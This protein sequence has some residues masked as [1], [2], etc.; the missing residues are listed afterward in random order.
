MSRKGEGA[1]E[2]II[3]EWGLGKASVHLC[4]NLREGQYLWEEG[5]IVTLTQCEVHLAYQHD[6]N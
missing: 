3:T 4:K 6:R 5:N 1:V 2:D